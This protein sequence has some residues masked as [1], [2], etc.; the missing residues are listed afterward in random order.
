MLEPLPKGHKRYLVGGLSGYSFTMMTGTDPEV[1]IRAFVG[2]ARW[3]EVRDGVRIYELPEGDE[4][5]VGRGDVIIKKRL[6]P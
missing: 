2:H 1:V 5:S 4:Y 6:N 3:D